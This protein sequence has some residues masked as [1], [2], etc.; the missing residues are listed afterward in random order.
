MASFARGAEVQIQHPNLL[1]ILTDQLAPGFLGASGSAVARTPNLDRLA[2]DGV[3]FRRAYV[4]V[5]QCSP[6]R[7]SMFTG[8]YPHQHG[9]LVIGKDDPPLGR[10]RN[11]SILPET[12]P[13]LGLAFKAAGYRMGYCG[14]WHMGGDETPH[15]GWTDF[16][17]T[18]RYWKRGTDFYERYLEELGLA[19]TFHEDHRTFGFRAAL[20]TGVP[21]SG[22]TRIPAQHARTA[23]AVQ[24]AIDFIDDRDERPWTFCL[25][26][27][28]PHPPV[29]SPGDF[30]TLIDPADVELPVS[31]ADDLHDKPDALRRSLNHRWVRNMTEPDWRRLIAHYHGL[32]AHVDTEVGRLL[33]HLEAAGLSEDT[34]VIFTSDHGENMGSHRMVAKGPSMY[35]ESLGVP[36]IVRQAGRIDGGRVHDDLFSTI[37]F[38]RTCGVLCGVDVRAG[39]GLDFSATLTDG[40]PGPRRHVFAEFY[41]LGETRDD[42]MFVKSVR[43]DRWKLNLWLYDRSELYDLEVDPHEMTNLIDSVAQ[44]DVRADLAGRILAWVRQTDD[45]LTPVVERAALRVSS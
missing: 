17:R 21:P 5:P 18:N 31:L 44:A 20:E 42:F 14:P 22:A 25:S 2:A 34:V 8:Q 36:F 10:L 41:T 16:W 33:D 29:I 11:R 6:S 38:V 37:D 9:L 30:S 23:W 24:Q 12:V 45:P 27:K 28:D 1:I 40:E 19:A 13:S 43:G 15:H 32:V 7:A 4:P 39:E 26:I 3:L 35:E